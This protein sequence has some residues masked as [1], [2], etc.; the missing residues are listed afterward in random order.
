MVD[1]DNI[2][3]KDKRLR[4][5]IL[6]V[7]RNIAWHLNGDFTLVQSIIKQQTILLENSSK[8]SNRM[9]EV[10]IKYCYI[11]DYEWDVVSGMSQYGVG[12]LVFTDGNENYLVIE[13]KQLSYGSGR[14]Q[15]VA[16]RKAR[17]R[18]EEQAIKYMNAFRK[19]HPEAKSIIGVAVASSEWTFYAFKG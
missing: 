4:D 1:I 11:F 3:L 2:K 9:D 13:V 17:R 5:Y 7:D 18:V 6:S 14:N 8:N 19:K 16:R 15:C 12:D 10:L